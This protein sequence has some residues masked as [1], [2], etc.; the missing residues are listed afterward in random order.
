MPG[1]KLLGGSKV[2]SAFHHSE[3]DQMSTTPED[4]MLKGTL[5]PC[6]GSLAL[7]S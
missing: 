1:S 6:S 7:G 3:I 4:V 5:S 2:N